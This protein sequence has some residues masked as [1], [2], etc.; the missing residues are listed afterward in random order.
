MIILL[1]LLYRL[2]VG[3]LLLR[4]RVGTL[5]NRLFLC[6]M[7]REI[8]DILGTLRIE[9]KGSSSSALNVITLLK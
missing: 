7:L 6:I 9:Y 8:L 4:A 1:L 3:I 2:G 5:T